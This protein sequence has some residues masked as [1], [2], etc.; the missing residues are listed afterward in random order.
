MNDQK[1]IK[2]IFNLS[3]YD[4]S[5]NFTNW[6]SL[7]GL[8]AVTMSLLFCGLC[9]ISSDYSISS[10]AWMPNIFFDWMH[11]LFGFLMQA[12]M[13][14]IIADVRLL[15]IAFFM[16]FPLVVT[17]NALDLAFDSSMSGFSLHNVTAP[18]LGAIILCNTALMLFLKLVSSVIVFF[19][20]YCMQ[21]SFVMNAVMVKICMILLGLFGAYIVQLTYFYS[22]HVLEYKKGIWQSYKDL[23]AMIH[24]KT[25]FLMKILLLQLS[26]VL[27]ATIVLYVSLGHVI[28]VI[29]PMLLW[30][31]ERLQ[32]R[33]EPI[34]VAMMHN[35]FYAWAYLLLYAWVCL[36]TAHAY[37]Q[38]I[39][40]PIG[41][42]TCASCQSCEK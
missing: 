12:P 24:G 5:N 11:K 36:V 14:A 15:F 13:N 38:L 37:R 33:I 6:F 17:Q 25:W 39:C 22:M 27:A 31:F 3:Y 28:K 4:F 16:M 42:P 40:P 7:A 23:V 26:L 19:I 18:Y 10:W 8:L 20:L 34:F 35:F 29:M 1:L 30:F 9:Y 41:N 32:L 2:K 21:T